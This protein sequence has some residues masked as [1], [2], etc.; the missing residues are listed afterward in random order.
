M[1]DHSYVIPELPDLPYRLGRHVH[2]DI[3]NGA[4]RALAVRPSK[5]NLVPYRSFATMTVFDQGDTSR[6]TTEAFVGML[7]TMPFA[8]TFTQRPD[9]DTGDQRQALYL[10]SQTVDPWPGEDYDGTSTDAPAK[11]L[12]DRGV[13]GSYKWLFGE[14]EVREWVTWFSPV[15]IG[16]QWQMQ[17]FYPDDR[18]YLDVAGEVVGGHAIRLV[19]YS[20]LHEAY[21]VVNS[22]G[23]SWGQNGRA[24]LRAPDL[25]TL[26]AADGDALTV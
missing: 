5:R 4:H 1:N 17:M 24:W 25:A 14:D 22:W 8:P 15:V 11:I 16:I 2:H 9:Y 3:R 23:R 12:K 7:R 10:A 20:K 26:L 18:G 13:I 21:R 6:C 19:Q